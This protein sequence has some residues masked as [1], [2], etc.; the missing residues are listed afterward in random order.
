MVAQTAALFGKSRKKYG[1]CQSHIRLVTSVGEH[2]VKPFLQKTNLL[3][4]KV[5][6]EDTYE[7]CK[8]AS[9]T[10]GHVLWSCLKAQEAWECSKLAM[11]S[12]RTKGISFQDL[13]WQLM[14]IE[15]IRDDQATRVVTIAWALWHNRNE[16]RN[17]DVRKSG[18][19]LVKWAMDYLAE[20]GAVIESDELLSLVVE[21]TVSWSPP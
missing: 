17:G 15:G 16:L 10:A 1:V 18:Q 13:M 7:I 2:G 5:I 6:Q 8:E 14:M 9:E 12:N 20:Y 11:N 3:R 19:V 21:Q 4:R